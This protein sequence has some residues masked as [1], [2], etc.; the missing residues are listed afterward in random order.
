MTKIDIKITMPDQVKDEHKHRDLF[1]KCCDYIT[2]CESEYDSKYH[3][4]YLKTIY[5][6]L[7]KAKRVPENLLPLLDK[8]EEFMIKYDSDREN[9]DAETMFKSNKDN[10]DK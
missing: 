1:D 8:L 5:N 7:S 6:K 10:G 2:V 3:F 9:L 4:E